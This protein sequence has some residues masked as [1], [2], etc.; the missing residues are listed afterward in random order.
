MKL[1][2]IILAC[3]FLKANCF[4]SQ[5]KG[6]SYQFPERFNKN[7][8]FEPNTL[9]LDQKE[10][11]VIGLS[12]DEL[13]NLKI[14][15]S[16]GLQMSFDNNFHYLEWNDLEKYLKQLIDTLTPVGFEN[17]YAYKPFIKRIHAPYYTAPKSLNL[18]IPISA[19][20]ESYNEAEL[21]YF[22]AKEIGYSKYS[23][24]YYKFY[25]N[26]D[27]EYDYRYHR[28]AMSLSG[29]VNLSN[30][31]EQ[32]DI[33]NARVDSFAL[34]CLNKLNLDPNSFDY[35]S[36]FTKNNSDKKTKKLNKIQPNYKNYVID[37]VYFNKVKKIAT[38]EYIKTD[39]ELANFQ[40]SLAIAFR[41]YLC[42][43]NSLKNLFYIIESCRRIIYQNPNLV[44]KG[45]LA[46]HLQFTKFQGVNFSI[47]KEPKLLFADSLQFIKAE[48]HPLIKND[49]KPFNT[50]EDAFFYFVE[51]AKEKKFNEATFSLALYYYF[52]KD[53]LNF[54][55]ELKKYI[56]NG[57]GINNNLA[58]NLNEH[59]YPLI[60]DG[61][62]NILIDNST[63]FSNKDN[64]FHSLQRTFQN[65]DIKETFKSDSTIIEITLMNEL[66]GVQPRKLYEYQKLKW[67]MYQ[68]Y[69]DADETVFY[70]RRYNGKEDMEERA[71]R[72]K[73]NKNLIIYAPEFYNWFKDHNYK[74]I[75]F[76]K[77]KYEYSSAMA[78]EE[79][80]N[81]YTL[82]Y[83]NF[84]DNRPFFYKCVRNGN[85]RKEKISEMTK[86]CRDY[87][88]YKE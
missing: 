62:I 75:V 27:R 44:K 39:F 3:L 66:L 86:S 13:V 47:L 38:E 1:K 60:K 84:F 42:G 26:D 8:Y 58:I 15:K 63:I 11:K 83:I 14:M 2:V 16:Y 77:V 5:L 78:A 33:I 57:G 65:K 34:E 35:K 70:K 7:Y 74:G 41:K 64:Y 52:K 32:S 31:Y 61:K 68:L 36:Y 40:G 25:E 46:E 72:N 43:D 10:T 56:D 49:V 12:D 82:L 55:I 53:E 73:Y 20:S 21:V 45:F 59:Y 48:N 67:H 81:F 76:Q 9:F 79:Y 30:P 88:F 87:L 28:I 51:L 6:N 23:T 18:S 71:K 4:Y 37:S 54:K 85:I 22:L 17:K 50:Y 29:N 69:N 80:H 19:I 24:E